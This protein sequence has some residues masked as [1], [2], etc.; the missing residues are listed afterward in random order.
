MKALMAT[1]CVAV[2]CAAAYYFLQEYQAGVRQAAAAELSALQRR[3]VTEVDTHILAY[4]KA[5]PASEPA[6]FLARCLAKGAITQDD[7]DAALIRNGAH[8]L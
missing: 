7:I 3:C 4:I 5:G 6:E 2:L 1:T 8:K